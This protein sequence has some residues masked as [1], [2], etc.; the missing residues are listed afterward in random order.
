MF[1]SLQVEKL[2]S[3]LRLPDSEVRALDH[4]TSLPPEA[5]KVIDKH[6]NI[7]VMSED[8]ITGHISDVK[9]IESNI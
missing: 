9:V 2:E 3:E 1:S 7:W 4:Q 8:H 5:S 6:S